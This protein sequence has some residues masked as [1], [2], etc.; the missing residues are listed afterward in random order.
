M[1][2]QSQDISKS[3]RHGDGIDRSSSDDTVV[4][5][6]DEEDVSP[7]D[8]E[9]SRGREGFDQDQEKERHPHLV[10]WYSE[11]D[12]ENP[13][14]PVLPTCHPDNRLADAS[15]KNWPTSYKAFV[16]LQMALLTF[17]VY[18]GSAIYTAGISG[19]NSIM[20]EFDVSMTTALV[21]LTVFVLGYG[22]SPMIW[23]PLSEFPSIGRLPVCESIR[24][25]ELSRT[26]VLMDRYGNI[27]Y[28]CRVAVPH[29]LC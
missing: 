4:E 26:L 19:P 5:G 12:Q 22:I 9:P 13:Y 7:Q 27:V 20:E 18:V 2:T 17:A 14:V 11:T 24:S 1:R 21:G 16:A 23:A 29:H 3:R 6:R 10:D 8:A 25:A 15:S 28:L